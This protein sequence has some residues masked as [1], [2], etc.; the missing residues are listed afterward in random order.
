MKRLYSLFRVLGFAGAFLVLML[1]MAMGQ[2]ASSGDEGKLYE[3]AKKEGTVVWY[4]SMALE[5]TKEIAKDF[6]AKYPGVKV[7]ALRIVGI[8]QYQRLVMETKAKQYIADITHLSDYPAM[9]SLVQEG[10]I[11]EWKVPT[12]DRIPGQ[13]R[14]GNHSYSATLVDI[15]IIYNT[16]KVTPEEVKILGKSWKGVLDPRFKGRF[17]VTTMKCG[18]CYSGIHMFLDPKNEKI[19]GPEF[20]KAVAAQKPMV[21]SEVTVPVDRVVAG[22]HDFTYWTWTAIGYLKWAQGAPVRWVCPE[23]TP[24]FGSTWYGISKKAPHPNAARLFLNWIMSEDGALSQQTTGYLT[25]LEGVRDSRKMI[26]EPWYTPVKNRYDM[27]WERWSKNYNKDMEVWNKA[28]LE[29]K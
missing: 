13:F 26:G 3:L 27:N 4:T 12:S 14:I 15:G 28:M 16:N 5:P 18:T 25:T 17:A 20:I 22:E 29:A 11:D 7:E 6:E 24:Q 19:F 23:P 8:A 21:Y 10:F 9:K 2:S 1:S